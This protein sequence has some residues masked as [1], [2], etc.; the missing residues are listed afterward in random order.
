MTRNI[1][2]L[3]FVSSFLFTGCGETKKGEP[4]KNTNQTNQSDA[5]AKSENKPNGIDDNADGDP[6]S[7]SPK[8]PNVQSG[9]L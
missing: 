8:Y 6:L 1:I 9:D 7:L 5:E 4:L 2:N 3:L